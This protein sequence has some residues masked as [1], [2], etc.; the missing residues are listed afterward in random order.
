LTI[1]VDTAAPS[2]ADIVDV[3]PDPR[4]DGVGSID[5]VFSEPVYGLDWTD[6]TLTR[7]GGAVSLST[8]T[9][10]TT[11]NITWTL[12]NLSGLTGMVVGNATTTYDL[13]LTAAGSD[14]TDAA[15]NAL[16]AN[17]SDTWILIP[18]TFNGTPNAD[19]YVFIAAGGV[20]GL[21]TMHQLKV[22]LFGS[23]MVTYLYDA[24]YSVSLSIDAKEG[25][26]K[27]TVTGGPG[28]DTTLI[29]RYYVQHTG[30]GATTAPGYYYVYGSGMET[31]I[32]NAGAGTA[33]RS[34][35]N[36]SQDNGD[37][38]TASA[39]YRTGSMRSAVG[40]PNAFN[41]SSTGYD[42]IYG[43]GGN[44]GINDRADLYDS[45][46]NDYYVSRAG[47]M[48]N[49]YS[50]IQRTSGG[51]GTAAFVQATS[52]FEYVYGFATAGGVDEAVLF[53][54]NGD[55]SMRFEPDYTSGGPV[56]PRVYM[57]R[58]GG[59]FIYAQNFKKVT[60]YP[61]AGYDQ[62]AFFDTA[63][64][65]VFTASPT[66]ARLTGPAGS[67]ILNIAAPDQG[68]PANKWD[69]VWAYSQV[70]GYDKA[71]LT[72]ST[73]DDTFRAYG[74]PRTV[75]P[76]GMG[77][78]YARLAG[79]GY[80]L[81]VATFEE[82]YTN[83]LTGNDTANLYDGT[84]NDYFWAKLGAAVLTDGTVSDATGDLVTP[85]TYYYKVYGFNSAASDH[86]NA[87]GTSGGTNTK[88][89]ITPLDYLLAT[90]GS[91]TDAP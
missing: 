37:V 69:A 63:G 91:W 85:N 89:V 42:Q 20:G 24:A 19:T 7:N 59:Y 55:D 84:A 5:I 15:G 39:H 38:F 53:G 23:P 26:D 33:Q 75:Y 77:P 3:I 79:T 41:N 49:P 16:A 1:T 6:L 86:V 31:I 54:S 71:Y 80:S 74:K 67:N 9:L 62:V 40:N 45:N 76:S 90:Y 58:P 68:I 30:P 25:S 52:G 56:F 12:S 82:V 36:D 64:N 13:T 87:Y 65:D 70:G 14:I 27:L 88:R 61:D 44:G 60:G 21:P 11:D 72:G 57:T 18:T 73:G 22:T 51:T 46:G 48:V 47:A 10:S 8:A 4:T 50:Y 35:L 43:I 32:D 2:S 78:G 28:T 17:A 81:Q 66:D 29:N 34:T 83:L